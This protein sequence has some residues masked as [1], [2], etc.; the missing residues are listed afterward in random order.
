MQN[1]TLGVSPKVYVP[2][3]GQ[4]IAGAAFLIA[5]LDVEGRTA[6]ATGL[7]TLIAGYTATPGN[8][9]DEVDVADTPDDG[10][11]PEERDLH[12]NGLT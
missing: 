12:E 5:G 8:V 10:A 6:I 3:I 1:R 7:G 9:V 4:I 11:N 2:A